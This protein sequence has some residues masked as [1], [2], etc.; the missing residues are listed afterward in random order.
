MFTDW[1]DYQNG[2]YSG[3]LENIDLLLPKAVELLSNHDFFYKNALKMMLEWVVCVD[4]NLTNTSS[5]RRA[6]IGQATCSYV[7]KVPEVITRI[8]WSELNDIQQNKANFAANKII[9][10]YEERNNELYK[11]MGAKMLF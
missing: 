2:M 11:N 8:A 5:N 4:Y 7:Y 1:E 10:I 9:K 6:W 3:S